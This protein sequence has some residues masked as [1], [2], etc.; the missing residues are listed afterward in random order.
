MR[1][2][3]NVRK[4]KQ[5]MMKN[6]FWLL[7]IVLTAACQS[8]EKDTEIAQNNAPIHFEAISL[9]GDT[10]I[11]PPPSEKLLER[12]EEKKQAYLADSNNVNHII[13]FGRFTAY[14]GDYK[15]AIKIYTRGIELFPEDARLLRHRGHRYITIRA[16]DKAIADLKNASTLREGKE[17]EVE[18][19][20]MPNAQN[21]PVSTLHGNI[22]YH[23]GLAHYLNNEMED[24]LIAYE[25]CLN[26]GDLD[27]NI[28][29]SVHWM[30]MIMR[31]MGKDG[32]DKSLEPIDK[33]MNII[34]NMSYHKLC[35]F[36]KG[37][38][39]EEEL[40]AGE[41]S[42]SANDAISYGLGNWHFYNG[43]E[44]KAKAIF[45]KIVATDGW[46]SFGYIAAEADVARTFLYVKD[47]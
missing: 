9:L 30:Y 46:N 32:T 1:E 38:L 45:E 12:Y 27:D 42:Y 43:N 8:V 11:S 3:E 21:I 39:T 25:N 16:F 23:L 36:Y 37:L 19:D 2:C 28:V 17:N 20:G 10:L 15:E 22:Y 13:W 33:D 6:L 34:E 26:S 4:L 35:L 41:E 18:P 44:K 40:T 5:S 31:R 7:I 24:A 47:K 14:K 29:S